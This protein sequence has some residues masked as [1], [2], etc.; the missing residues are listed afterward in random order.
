VVRARS[1][2]ALTFAVLATAAVAF[3]LLQ[4]LVIPAIPQLEATLHTSE[5]GASWL[6]TAYLLSAAIFT[7]ILGRVGDMLGKERI[8]VAVLVALSV[9]SLISALATSLPVMLVGRIIQGAGGAVFPLA[10]GIIRD[11]FPAE[12]VAGAIGVMSAIL[13]A[14]AGAGIVLAGP[15]LVHLNYHWLFWI[16]LIMSVAATIATALFVPESPVRSPGRINWIGAVLMSGWL[17]TGLLAISY[18]PTWGWGNSS[19]LGLFG[20]TAVLLALWVLSET[21]SRSPLVDMQMMRIRAV[22]TTNLAALLFGFGMFAMFIV[23]PQFTQTPTHVGYGFGASVTQSGLYLLPFAVMMV[24]VA[25]MT[26]RLT[27]IVGSKMILVAGSLFAASSYLVLVLD[28][29]EEWTMYLATGLLGIGIAMGFASMANLIIEAVPAEQTGVATGMNTNIRN[30]GAALGS[31]IATS[32]VISTLL[33]DGYPKEHGYVL[34]FAVSGI[35]LVV[36]ALVALLI[37][38]RSA[39]SIVTREAHPAL[40]AEAQAIVGAI[41]LSPDDLA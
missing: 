39:P 36:A 29:S 30:I 40:T 25:P 19:V 16:P 21:R 28:H 4:S 41:A 31:G 17:I 7:P 3:S 14:G 22:W 26:G 6:L 37:P 8:I 33:P 5:S 15:I 24:I 13:G 18:A 27:V 23:L 38:R 35:G 34:A 10:F 32:L 2:Y 1:N 11:E 20:A 9:G 12:R